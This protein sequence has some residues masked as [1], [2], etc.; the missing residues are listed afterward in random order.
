MQLQE[1]Y[2]QGSLKTEPGL[3]CTAGTAT[4]GALTHAAQRQPSVQY[5]SIDPAAHAW[6][7]SSMKTSTIACNAMQLQTCSGKPQATIDRAPGQARRPA[8]TTHEPWTQRQTRIYSGRPVA[9]APAQFWPASPTTPQLP[10]PRRWT[11]TLLVTGL[12]AARS[13]AHYL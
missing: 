4:P 10:L 9:H 7:R 8:M 2:V 11:W 6:R 13:S 5:R 1:A 12:L 3:H